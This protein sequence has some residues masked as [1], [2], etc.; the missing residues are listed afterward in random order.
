[1]QIV[2][3]F[4]FLSSSYLLIAL[5]L[6]MLFGV[7]RIV[8]YAHGELYMIGGYIFWLSTAFLMGKVDPWV[9]LTIAMVS[10]V[11]VTSAL[12]LALQTGIVSRLSGKPFA[13]FMC[14][15]GISYILQVLVIQLAGP[16]GRSVPPLFPGIFRFAGGIFPI[17]RV[18]VAGF[19]ITLLIA[20]WWFLMRTKSGSA[21]RAAAQ[22]ETGAAL[23]G[24]SMRRV[25]IITMMIGAGLAGIAGVLSGSLLGVTPFM[26]MAAIWKSFLIVIVGGVGSILGAVL[27]A[28]LFGFMDTILT[29]FG[30][31]RFIALTDAIIMLVI[32][33]FMP[34]GLLGERE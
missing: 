25:G 16:I 6:A 15:L 33:T 2:A 21:I 27:A 22:N 12:G 7:M 9:I 11:V 4:V 31:A 26:G 13:I 29:V 1:M 19:A 14:T 18:V 20:L 3:N 28:L 17:Q 23:Q 34:Y 24:I 10:S 5:G 32:L 8:N 30:F